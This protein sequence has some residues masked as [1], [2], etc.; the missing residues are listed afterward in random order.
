VSKTYSIQKERFIQFT[1]SLAKM[2]GV[3][4][5]IVI[6]QLSFLL[7][8]PSGGIEK[9]GHRWVWNTYDQWQGD[10]FPFWSIATIK[11]IFDDLEKQHV[12]ES[13]QF[14]GYTSRKKYYRLNAGMV[15]KLTLEAANEI[16]ISSI[17]DDGASIS[18]NCAVPSAQFDTMDQLNLIRSST[19][20]TSESTTDK[21]LLTLSSDPPPKTKPKAGSPSGSKQLLPATIFDFLPSTFTEG[22]NF[23][24]FRE[25]WFG[26]VE[27]RKRIK[28]PLTERAMKLLAADMTAWGTRKSIASLNQTVKSGRWTGLF[29]PDEKKGFQNPVQSSPRLRTAEEA[30]VH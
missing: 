27:H 25:A 19:D 5:A 30:N 10:H 6:Q 28:A 12:V 29:D 23:N 15:E 16:P 26:F 20:N 13:K 24:E 8:M 21:T 1:P 4:A 18:S 3:N 9:E 2:A 11:R 17:C 7:N 14:D 22:G